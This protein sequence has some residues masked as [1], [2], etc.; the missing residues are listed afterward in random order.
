MTLPDV[1]IRLRHVLFWLL[2]SGVVYLGFDALLS[3]KVT[4][5]RA[6]DGASDI[7]IARSYDQHFYVEGS[8]NGRAVTFLIDTG[9]TTVTVGDDVARAIGLAGGVPADFHTAGGRV[10]GRIVPDNVVQVGGIRVSG[11]RVAVNPALRQS[12]L[13]QN[14]LS[15]VALTQEGDRLVIRLN[16]PG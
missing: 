8:I 4:R 11:L 15:K 6:I 13:G 5:A 16:G 12:L 7:S 14:F 9:A 1:G 3:P 2:V 10:V